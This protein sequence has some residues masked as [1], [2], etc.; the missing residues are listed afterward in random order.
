MMHSFH[1]LA[2]EI[3][4]LLKN[5]G[6]T[7]DRGDK[8]ENTSPNN[9][10]AV[11]PCRASRSPLEIEGCRAFQSRGDGRGESNQSLAGGVTHVT[12]VTRDFEQHRAAIAYDEYPAE[13]HAILAPLKECTAPNWMMPDRWEVVL[14]DARRFLDQW[15]STAHAMGWTALDLFGVH[16]TRPAVRSDVMGLLLLLQGGEVV[17]LTE[18]GATIRR[19]SGAVLRFPRP[20]AGGVLLSEA[21]HG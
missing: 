21:A 20:A 7:G 6:D 18:E 9:V 16:P 15:S 19:P 3:S 11:T 14:H 4:T 5:R 12:P 8:F 17:A 13:W 10:V 1:G 2:N